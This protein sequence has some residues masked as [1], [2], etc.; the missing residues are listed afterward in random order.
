MR[1]GLKEVIIC[2]D[3]IGRYSNRYLQIRFHKRFSL[4]VVLLGVSIL[5]ELCTRSEGVQDQKTTAHK[6]QPY[7]AI[8][9][10]VHNRANIL[11]A[12]TTIVLF[13]NLDLAR[14]DLIFC[15]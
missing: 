3:I 10:I 8:N 6:F 12:N 14:I 4:I 1:Q 11:K 9:L 5:T 2:F 13:F 15:L 7:Y